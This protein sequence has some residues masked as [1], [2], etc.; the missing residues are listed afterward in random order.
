[1]VNTAIGAVIGQGT[2][3]GQDCLS[4][5]FALLIENPFFNTHCI[6]HDNAAFTGYSQAMMFVFLHD[7]L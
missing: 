4:L 5:L 7:N 3:D 1:M 6:S 2:H